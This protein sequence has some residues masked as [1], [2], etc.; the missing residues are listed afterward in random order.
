[1][2]YPTENPETR[3]YLESCS[4]HSRDSRP[5]VGRRRAGQAVLLACVLLASG[6]A[7]AQQT[8]PATG[9][10]APTAEPQPGVITAGKTSSAAQGQASTGGAQPGDAAKA[11]SNLWKLKGLTVER[12]EFAG[13]SFSAKDTLPQELAQQKG[14]PLD[15]E[16]LRD[17]MR[18]LYAT[19]RYRNL[20]VSGTRTAGGVVLTFSGAARFYVGRVEITGVKSE[21]LASILESA[22]NLQPGTAFSQTTVDAAVKNVQDMLAQNGYYEATVTQSTSPEPANQQ[23]NVT[24]AVKEGVQAR[25]GA[26]NAAGDPGM[27]AADFRKQAKLKLNHKVNRETSTNALTKLRKQYEKQSRLEAKITLDKKVYQQPVHHLDYDFTAVQGPLVT[28]ETE[29][30][31]LGKSRQHL[32]I[33]IYQESTVD[34]DLLNEGSHNLREYLEREGYFDATVSVSV[35]NPDAQHEHILYKIDKG[36][37]HKVTSVTISGAKYFQEDLLRERMQV[38]KADHYL[39]NGRYSPQLL[40][41]D[42][43]AF[44]NLYR[45][46]GFNDV[47]VTTAVKGVE[48]G[49]NGKASKTGSIMVAITIDEGAQ[50]KFGS[51]T[52]TGID[53]ARMKDVKALMN[54]ATGEPYSLQTLAGDRDAILGYYLSHGFD[55][56]RITVTPTRETSDQQKEDVALTVVEGPQVFVDRILLS[57]VHYTKPRIVEREFRLHPGDPLDQSALLDT[58][59]NLYNLALFNEVN[60]AVQNPTGDA[61]RKNVLIQLAEA[62][63]WDLTYGFGFEAQTGT[64]STNC[65]AQASAGYPNCTQEGK[66]G[67]S[68]RVSLDVTRINVDGRDDTLTLHTTY[69]LL[70]QIATLTFQKPHV[71]GKKNYDLSVSGGYSNVQ[72][73]STYQAATLQGTIKLTQRV[74][75]QD[76]LIYDYEYRRVVINQSSLQVAKNLIPLLGQPDRTG[77]PG[78][79]WLHDTRQPSPLDATH[80]SYTSVQEFLSHTAF[81]SETDFNRLDATNSTYYALDKKQRFILARNT[82]F[83]FETSFGAFN[84]AAS[85]TQCQGG[86][87]G[88]INYPTCVQVPLPERLY[89]GGATSHRGFPINGA[90]PRDLL[91]GYPVGGTAVFVNTTELRFPGPI[92]PVIGDALGLVIFHDM[93]NVFTNVSDVGPSFGRF[94]QPNSGTCQNTNTGGVTTGGILTPYPGTCDFAYFSHAVG[95]GLR[96]KT[97]IGPIRVDFSYNL[98]PPLYPIVQDFNDNLGPHE[99]QASHFNFF[100]SIGQSF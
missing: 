18:R 88:P 80:G 72:N 2:P 49:A 16:A 54:T 46:N 81:G 61:T 15:P 23:V 93:G 53:D 10:Q 27:S 74:R 47:N 38:Q 66:L 35:N 50:Q 51:V 42:V 76:T 33:P 12:I 92:L 68:P 100:F 62:K 82:R 25:I 94:H 32:I 70:E 11:D 79:T 55:Q 34:T 45:A 57:G 24:I 99:G 13:V 65:A 30:L 20:T 5:K 96:Y 78:L 36:Q 29:G 75:R 52:L 43:A 84:Q 22:T 9:H 60:T 56:V 58:Q 91:T 64:P 7:T 48:T 98:N 71:R 95:L 31:K 89:A 17:T 26:V 3:V 41:A 87:N 85:D 40:Q 1:M 77:G 63:R 37:K 6:V 86:A 8:T 21:R 90:G 4:L 39:R 83:G 73:I 28:I 19:G 14:K 59:R 67:V 69:G 97:P 44:Q